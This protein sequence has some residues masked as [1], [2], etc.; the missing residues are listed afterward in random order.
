MDLRAMS[1]TIVGVSGSG[2]TVAPK[3]GGPPSSFP[4]RHSEPAT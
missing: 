2:H 1:G 3:E 4:R